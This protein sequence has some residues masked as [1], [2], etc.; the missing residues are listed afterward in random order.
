MMERAEELY[1]DYN[2]SELRS[3]FVDKVRQTP[4]EE[5]MKDDVVEERDK[6]DALEVPTTKVPA[7][8]APP[9]QPSGV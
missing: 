5:A 6:E 9:S 3:E 1:P 7:V 2:L 8:E 4:V